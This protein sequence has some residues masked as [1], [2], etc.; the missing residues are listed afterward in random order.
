[1]TQA[2]RHICPADQPP[3]RHRGFVSHTGDAVPVR[4]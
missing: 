2:Q 1:M 4:L 3:K